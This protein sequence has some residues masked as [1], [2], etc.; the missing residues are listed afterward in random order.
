MMAKINLLTTGLATMCTES[1]G[2]GNIDFSWLVYNPSAIL[3]AD[4]I[5]LTKYMEESLSKRDDDPLDKSLNLIFEILEDNNVVKLKNSKN[6]FNDDISEKLEEKISKDLFQLQKDESSDIRIEECRGDDHRNIFIEDKPYCFPELK[7][8]YASLII[9]EAWDA[10]CLFSERN[11]DFLKYKL[12]LQSIPELQ[13]K[14]QSF[15]NIFSLHLPD[16]PLMHDYSISR[17]CST[18]RYDDKCK[19]EYLTK[20]EDNLMYYLDLR[21]YDEI[22]QIKDIIYEIDKKINSEEYFCDFDLLLK[23]YHETKKQTI[24]TM[25]TLFPKIRKWTNYSMMVCSATTAYGY[26][27]GS[28]LLTVLGIGMGAANDLVRFSLNDFENK[29]KWVG[30]K[31]K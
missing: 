11:L 12:N 22:N 29:T 28:N 19:S 13:S 30:F 5:F 4:T 18:C 8:I 23:E 7:S 1:F 10:K 20:T 15:D 14:S 16:L 31:V 26:L 27:T 6:V 2:M 17:R 3:W 9:S 25:H 24:K 21:E